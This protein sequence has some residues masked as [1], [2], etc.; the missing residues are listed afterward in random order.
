MS[1]VRPWKETQRRKALSSEKFWAMCGLYSPPRT[2]EQ[3]P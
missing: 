1:L 2:P 3:Q